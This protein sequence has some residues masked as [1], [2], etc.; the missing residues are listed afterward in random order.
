[1]GELQEKNIRGKYLDRI[2]CRTA[3]RPARTNARHGSFQVSF[4]LT[5]LSVLRFLPGLIPISLGLPYRPH[6][7][8]FSVSIT[9]Q[10]KKEKSSCHEGQLLKSVNCLVVNKFFY[11]LFVGI[12]AYFVTLIC[13]N[14]QSNQEQL[15]CNDNGK[16][17]A[18]GFPYF[19]AAVIFHNQ[20]L[21]NSG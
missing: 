18:N 20:L 13:C 15:S 21:I 16:N 5:S 19:A 1:M 10:K 17:D 4:G 8:R 11:I 3:L 6:P 14:T 2:G 12:R 9:Y 7:L